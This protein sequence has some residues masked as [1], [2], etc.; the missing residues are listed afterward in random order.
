VAERNVTPRLKGWLVSLGFVAA[1]LAFVF[2]LGTIDRWL[3]LPKSVSTQ[4]PTK[5]IHVDSG[6]TIKPEGRDILHSLG[7]IKYW[8]AFEFAKHPEYSSSMV[9][10]SV[11]LQTMLVSGPMITKTGFLGLVEVVHP[12]FFVMIEPAGVVSIGVSQVVEDQ[13]WFGLPPD[14]MKGERLT[15]VTAQLYQI[16][17][18]MKT[19]LETQPTVTV[20]D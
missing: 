13:K 16:L 10:E 19:R 14:V 9:E 8:F 20:N 3:P 6:L 18:D 11:D 1:F 17:G 4:T 15:N 2:G 12:T 5:S 7:F